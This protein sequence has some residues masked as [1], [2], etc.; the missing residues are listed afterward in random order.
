[1]DLFALL[2][3][4]LN[5]AVKKCTRTLHRQRMKWVRKSE[6]HSRKRRVHETH[7]KYN[8]HSCESVRNANTNYIDV[9]KSN[10]ICLVLTVWPNPRTKRFLL[11]SRSLFF[12]KVCDVFLIN[13]RKRLSKL[14]YFL[15][16]KYMNHFIHVICLQNKKHVRAELDSFRFRFRAPLYLSSFCQS[17]AGR[18]E[19]KQCEIEKSSDRWFAFKIIYHYYMK[20]E[21][22]IIKVWRNNKK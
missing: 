18:I 7:K 16:K 21:K 11:T 19:R 14:Y 8:Q 20:E 13:N 17:S 4:I 10:H 9:D 1:M 22:Y 12:F 2:F 6:P 15:K 5:E 3:F